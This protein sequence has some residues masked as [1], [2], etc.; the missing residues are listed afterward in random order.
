MF[1]TIVHW[2][3]QTSLGGCE[4]ILDTFLQ[5]CTD[6]KHIIITGGDI[7]GPAVS[8]WKEHGA[9]VIYSKEWWNRNPF[10]WKVEMTL[11]LKNLPLFEFISWS[12]SRLPF[13]R[14]AL[15]TKNKR[16][17]LVHIGSRVKST[18]I[19]SLINSLWDCL[20]RLNNK[21]V[22]L[23][24]CS[25]YV[26]TSIKNDLYYSRFKSKGVL[27]GVRNSFELKYYARESKERLKLCT[28]SRLDIVKGHKTMI[29]NFSFLIKN[30]INA[31]FDIIGEGPERENIELQIK[32]LGLEN[33]IRL[34][35]NRKDVNNLLLDYDIFLFNSQ[36]LEGMGIALAEAMMM[37]VIPIVNNTPLMREMVGEIGYLYDSS[38]SFVKIVSILNDDRK[39][40]K[41]RSIQIRERA[42]ELFSPKYFAEQYLEVLNNFN[43]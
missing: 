11:I 38:D 25:N 29:D 16:S 2:I 41:Q 34:L 9:E 30:G 14:G 36:P 27:N 3:P 37:G 43:K 10:K 26:N 15:K 23:I 39:L 40:L 17:I 21:D 35:G 6:Y 28:V 33:N 4:I 18:Y 20:L 13:L 8:I 42:I 19:Q 22:F 5:G 32:S 24:G 1:K 12:P 7:K 31:T